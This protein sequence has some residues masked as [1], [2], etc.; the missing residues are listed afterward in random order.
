MIFFKWKEKNNS[1]KTVSK[2]IRSTKGL[3]ELEWTAKIFGME[4]RCAEEIE[5]PLLLCATYME[6]SGTACD[7][8]SSMVPH[9]LWTVWKGPLLFLELE[10]IKFIL[11]K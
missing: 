10:K 3:N 9:L 5:I 6:A 7:P 4:A 8:S 2:S 11:L 1:S